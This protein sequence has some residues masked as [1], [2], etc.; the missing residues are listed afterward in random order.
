MVGL[1]F[2]PQ[3]NNFRQHLLNTEIIYS[4][5]S[6]I[7]FLNDLNLYA[8]QLNKMPSGR[9]A[10]MGDLFH[11][12]FMTHRERSGRGCGVERGVTLSWRNEGDVCG[13]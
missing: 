11:F 8:Q 9:K 13:D 2:S 3:E 1:L 6:H 12:Y 4:Y 5:E 10:V 7:K